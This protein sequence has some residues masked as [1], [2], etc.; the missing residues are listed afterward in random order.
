MILMDKDKDKGKGRIA[1][2][3]KEKKR[4]RKMAGRRGVHRDFT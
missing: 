4:N 1:K 3:G 2:P